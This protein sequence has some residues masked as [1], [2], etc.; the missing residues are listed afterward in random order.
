M[1]W[2]PTPYLIGGELNNTEPGR[3][4]GWLDLLGLEQRV[5][6]KLRG[7]FH[8]DIRGASLQIVRAPGDDRI[9]RAQAYFNGFSLSQHGTAGDITAGFEPID[10]VDY[11]Y[12][13]WYSLENGRVVLELDPTEVRVCGVPLPW[14]KQMPISR[15]SQINN[16]VRFLTG[17][18]AIPK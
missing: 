14:Q 12:V 7:D 9:D 5:E 16:V 17:L 11:P 13:E 3:I 18:K 1:A 8:R 15:E 4:T 6:L 2:R 10:Y